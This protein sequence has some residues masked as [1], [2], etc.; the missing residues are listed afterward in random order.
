MMLSNCGV[1]DLRVAWTAGWSN[2]SNLKE[3][4]PEYSLEGLMLRWKLQY[5]GHLMQRADSIEKTQMLGKIEGRRRRERQ[6][7]MVGWHHLRDGHEFKQTLGDSKGQ[8]GLMCCSPWDHKE[9]DVTEQLN[10]RI[11]IRWQTGI[12]WRSSSLKTWL[13]HCYGPRFNPWLGN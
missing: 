4:N 2:K 7:E 13:L 8:E 5:F 1:E 10:K 11:K 12:P 6:D 9:S 3:T